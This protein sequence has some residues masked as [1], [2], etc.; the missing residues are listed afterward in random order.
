[1]SFIGILPILLLGAVLIGLGFYIWKRRR[2]LSVIP[3]AIGFLLILYGFNVYS[4][5]KSKKQ[6]TRDYQLLLRELGREDMQ[7]FIAENPDEETLYFVSLASQAFY[8]TT[9][10]FPSQRDRVMPLLA[11]YTKWVGDS[12]NFTVWT[13]T[14]SWK[15]NSPTQALSSGIT[16]I[17]ARTRPTPSASDR[18]ANTWGAEYLMPATNTW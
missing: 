8:R 11:E 1:M 4:N 17:L 5:A 3:L 13:N 16:R 10:R 14:R 12:R 18:S 7:Q 2:F 15:D 6:A 9:E